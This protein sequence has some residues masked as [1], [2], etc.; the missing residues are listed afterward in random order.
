[1]TGH[2]LFRVDITPEKAQSLFVSMQ[3]NRKKRV[4]LQSRDNDECTF[5][6]PSQMYVA[7]NIDS[8]ESYK[9]LF[10]FE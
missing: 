3:G 4:S 5:V 6:L 2:G 7:V 8:L 10:K 1:M 9:G